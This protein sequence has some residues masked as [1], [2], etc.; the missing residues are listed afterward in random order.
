MEKVRKP[1]QKP[2]RKRIKVQT[3]FNESEIK[4]TEILN[5]I[6]SEKLD[7][8]ETMVVSSYMGR[9]KIQIYGYRIQTDQEYSIALKRYEQKLEEYNRWRERH[10][11]EA[12][13]FEN[14][15]K[16]KELIS[17]KKKLETIQKLISEIENPDKIEA[18]KIEKPIR[19]VKLEI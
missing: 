15:D 18:E 4:I 17:L 13:K 16:R 5:W 2:E 11:E 10:E 9:G 19:A 14:K 7:P 3:T 1:P 6:K 8:N 12:K